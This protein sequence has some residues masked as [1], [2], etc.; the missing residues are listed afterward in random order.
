M[1]VRVCGEHNG[2]W[3][4]TNAYDFESNCEMTPI[5]LHTNYGGDGLA[6]EQIDERAAWAK[7]TPEHVRKNQVRQTNEA[8]EKE[9]SAESPTEVFERQDRERA[10]AKA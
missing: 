7:N 6:P 5:D 3:V 9:A 4:V 8:I 10:E 2:N 1:C